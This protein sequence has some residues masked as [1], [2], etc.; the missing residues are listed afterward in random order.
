MRQV[1]EF[2]SIYK[3]IV[4]ATTSPGNME[5][6]KFNGSFS[7]VERWGA[8]CARAPPEFGGSEMGNSLI[9]AYWRLAITASTSGFEKL[10]KALI[11]QY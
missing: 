9:S 6:E 5:F 10:S 3:K 4:V 11:G 7:S 2:F 1:F 8:L